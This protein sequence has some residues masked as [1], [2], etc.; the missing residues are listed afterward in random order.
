MIKK[1]S[2][3]RRDITER[4]MTPAQR[5]KVAG[6]RQKMKARN[7]RQLQK[8]GLKTGGEIEVTDKKPTVG[9]EI[10]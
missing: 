9:M 10:R 7:L 6:I 4:E 2:A 1:T 5:L 8:V 3:K